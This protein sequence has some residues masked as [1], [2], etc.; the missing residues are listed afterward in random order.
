M[1]NLHFDNSV[2]DIEADDN[3]LAA[4][5][6]NSIAAEDVKMHALPALAL[7]GSPPISLGVKPSRAYNALFKFSGHTLSSVSSSSIIRINQGR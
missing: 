6:I 4:S 2:G 5:R 1:D 7:S 3:A